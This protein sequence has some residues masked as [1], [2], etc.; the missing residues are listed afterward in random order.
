MRMIAAIL[1]LVAAPAAAEPL[2]IKPA[3]PL[4][5]EDTTTYV[6]AERMIDC[7]TAVREYIDR[8]MEYLKCL[9]DETTA[10]G[11]EL[12]RNV[13]RFNCRLA[14]RDKCD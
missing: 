13:D 5:M 2:C 6:G 8:T 11:Q 3:V 4:C 14:A 10:T 1:A 12:T 7:Q 9:N